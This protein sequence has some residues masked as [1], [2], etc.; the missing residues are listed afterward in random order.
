MSNPPLASRAMIQV[1]LHS[2]SQPELRSTVIRL[3]FS[4]PWCP[5]R[6]VQFGQFEAANVFWKLIAESLVL[7]YTMESRLGRISSWNW[8]IPLQLIMEDSQPQGSPVHQSHSFL[9]PAEIDSTSATNSTTAYQSRSRSDVL[10]RTSYQLP[11]LA[12]RP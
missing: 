7:R 2:W 1:L 5:R 4:N 3:Q 9:I 10:V 11:R 12:S 8:P 6:S